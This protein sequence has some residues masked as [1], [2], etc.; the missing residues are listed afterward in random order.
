MSR[1]WELLEG[2]SGRQAGSSHDWDAKGLDGARAA[3]A[4]SER[5]RTTA[6][7]G[8][9]G[10]DGGCSVRCATALP[11]CIRRPVK[12]RRRS[13]FPDEELELIPVEE[14][15]Q[16]WGSADKDEDLHRLMLN[17]LTHE[18]AYRCAVGVVGGVGRGQRLF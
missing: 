15:R 11:G 18:H 4:P 13:A 14:F 8:G 9:K 17:R 2:R 1:D 12:T 16:A 5:P 6:G 3:R 7:G 10:G